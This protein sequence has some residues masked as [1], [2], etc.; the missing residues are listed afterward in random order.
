[1]AGAR[2]FADRRI[3][4][5]D[6]VL[7]QAGKILMLWLIF[8]ILAT[9]A[10][11][12]LLRPLM[13]RPSAAPRARR[14]GIILIAGLMPAAAMF[15]YAFLGSPNVPGQP[16]AARMKDPAFALVARAEEQFTK[17]LAEYGAGNFRKAAGIW[18]DLLKHSPPHAPWAAAVAARIKDANKKLPEA[19]NKNDLIRN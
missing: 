14:I 1:V 16:Y 17:G 6:F 13:R 2:G 5:R 15:L 19:R 8:V 10:A 4:G 11:A 18:Q 12:I 3:G 7:P 9:A